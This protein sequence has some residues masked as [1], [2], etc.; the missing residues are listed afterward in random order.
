MLAYQLQTTVR[1]MERATRSM[2]MQKMWEMLQAH[3]LPA[4]ARRQTIP[5]PTLVVKRRA[6]HLNTGVDRLAR[7]KMSVAHSG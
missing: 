5:S 2:G 6:L 1:V 3:V 7:R 4:V